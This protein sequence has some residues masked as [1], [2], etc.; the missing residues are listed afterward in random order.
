MP[1]S[2]GEDDCRCKILC[3]LPVGTFNLH[4]CVDV[5]LFR[6]DMPGQKFHIIL[7]ILSPS[8]IGRGEGRGGEG[9]MYACSLPADLKMHME[10]AIYKSL[11]PENC[12]YCRRGWPSMQYNMIKLR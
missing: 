3:P 10:C 9:I 12:E 5:N 2:D 7:S 8:T 11:G 4:R 1:T 6:Y